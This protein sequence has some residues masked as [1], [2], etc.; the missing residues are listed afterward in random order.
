MRKIT[1]L[2]KTR[3]LILKRYLLSQ[4]VEVTLRSTVKDNDT[5][6]LWVID[7][8][9]QQRVRDEL[10]RFSDDPD[11]PKYQVVTPD[12][13]TKPRRNRYIDVRTQV[14]HNPTKGLTTSI[15]IALNILVFILQQFPESGWFIEKL[16]FSRYI[17]PPF[18]EI[19]D[20]QLWRL[21]TP[22]FLH[23]SLWHILF[24]MLWLYSLGNQLEQRDSSRHLLLFVVVSGVLS[25]V[26]QYLIAGP[27]FGGFSGVV[28]GL[29]GYIWM[30]GRFNPR[31]GYVIDNF[32]IFFMITWMILGIIGVLGNVANSAHVFGLVT[33]LVWG[34]IATGQLGKFLWGRK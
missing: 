34:L 8:E 13:P 27:G 2:P 20:G 9:H 31:S 17:A 15:L 5:V 29:L 6:E 16:Y 1:E 18:V 33:G 4:Q 3:G 25:N 22:I 14:F 28:Y 26:A 32:T 11:N 30:Q 19:S 12:N 24:N 21:L 23:F 7:D 10:S